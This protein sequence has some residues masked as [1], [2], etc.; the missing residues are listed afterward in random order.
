MAEQTVKFLLVDDLEENLVALEALLRRDGLELIR[1]RSGA[2]ALELLLVHDIALAL[3]DVQMPEMNGFELAELMRGLERTRR[4]PIIFVTALPAD[5][6]R[7]F[8]GYETGAVDYLQKPID[9]QILHSKTGVFF[10]LA[11][12]RN[13]LKENADK[14]RQALSQLQAHTDNS[15]LAYVSFDP[16][17]RITG[18]SDGA[19]RL[20]GW[21]AAEMK[22]R[23]YRH[24]SWLPEKTKTD[25][26]AVASSLIEGHPTGR[27]VAEFGARHRSG[28][29]VEGEWY[30]SAL[31]D[32]KGNLTSLSVQILDI[33]ERRKAEETQRLLMGELNH[34]VKNT[35][36]TVQAVAAHALRHTR[37]P[38]QFART[39]NGRIQSLAKAHSLLSATTWSGACLNDIIRDQLDLGALDVNRFQSNGPLLELVPQQ[40]LHIAMMVHELATNA[41]KYGAHSMPSGRISV[42]WR[43]EGETLVI[44]WTEAGGPAPGGMVRRGFGTTLI[45]QSARSEGGAAELVVRDDGLSWTIRM[46]FQGKMPE[47]PTGNPEPVEMENGMGVPAPRSDMPSAAGRRRV[48]IIEDEPLVA[49]DIASLLEAA[50]FEVVGTA[51]TVGEALDFIARSEIDVALLDGNLRGYPV[52]DVAQ[53]LD[54]KSIPFLFVSGYGEQNLPKDFAGRPILT[55][56]FSGEELI[57]GATGVL[58]ERHYSA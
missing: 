15:P 33:T 14:L 23:S 12:Q 20:F 8:R 51:A 37:D 22:G 57:E 1:A 46:R 54:G 38:A 24:V 47:E 30:L 13:E 11:R 32:C 17:L 35:L 5:E 45:E 52:D 49:M 6:N 41:S 18:W 28:R 27:D 10:E 44:V 2:E 34:R 16:L 43:L 29:M 36:A 53:A 7:R 56:P 58:G 26:S 31:Y 39:F 48:L 21:D 19:S 55:K 42:E 4:I 40:A 50:D 9:P 3:L 25:F